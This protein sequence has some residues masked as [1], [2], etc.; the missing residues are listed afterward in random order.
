MVLCSYIKCI[1]TCM[2]EGLGKSLA[3]DVGTGT[4]GTAIT[5]PNFS[6][7]LWFLCRFVSSCKFSCILGQEMILV[8]IIEIY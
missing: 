7:Y 5:V 1:V 3:K 4:S 8:G 6:E 2:M